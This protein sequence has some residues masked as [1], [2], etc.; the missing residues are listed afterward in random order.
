L[1]S[2]LSYGAYIS[3]QRVS[4]AEAKAAKLEAK[5]Q[6]LAKENRGM[7]TESRELVTENRELR[8]LTMKEVMDLTTDEEGGKTITEPLTVAAALAHKRLRDNAEA[9]SSSAVQEMASMQKKVKVKMEAAA[10]GKEEAEGELERIQKCVICFDGERQ[11]LF[12]PCSHL[13]VCKNCADLFSECPVCKEPI[14]TRIRAF[15]S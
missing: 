6:E 12:L 2:T 7:V 10:A 8:Q 3:F 15:T 4:S 5:T 9:G 13:S 1:Q 14:V 11:V